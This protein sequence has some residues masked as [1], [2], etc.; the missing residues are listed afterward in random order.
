M[1]PGRRLR[2]HEPGAARRRARGRVAEPLRRVERRV[3]RRCAS[4]WD[5]VHTGRPRPGFAD[6]L[7]TF[8]A[9][10]DVATRDAGQEGDAGVQ[11]V[12]A[13]H[14]RRRGRPR[15]VDED[16]VRGRRR[17]LAR[18]TPAATSPSASASTAWARS[19]TGSRST[20]GIVKPYG[21]TFLVFSDYMRPAVRLSALMHLPVVWVW[22]H[23]SI[24]LGEDGPTHQPVEHYAALRA[25]P[26]LWFVRPGRRERDGLRVEGRAR[27]RGRAGRARR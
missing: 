20:A 8:A 16:R 21:S 1:R 6:A 13:D 2:A 14:D 26:N 9:G 11:V 25:I 19:S 27:A 24:G 4:D 7:P 10:E 12:R 5:Q 15:R 3:P 22:T 18:P 17:L 23:D